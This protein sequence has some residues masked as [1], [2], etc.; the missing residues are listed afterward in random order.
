VGQRQRINQ[1]I[2]CPATLLTQGQLIG[3]LARVNR[4]IELNINQQP[5]VAK[6]R[7]PRTGVRIRAESWQVREMSLA[8][9]LLGVDYAE[10]LRGRYWGQKDSYVQVSQW[11]V[12]EYNVMASSLRVGRWLELV[13]VERRSNRDGAY[14]H[15]QRP[16][17]PARNKSSTWI[18]RISEGVR[19]YYAQQPEASKLQIAK[20]RQARAEMAARKRETIFGANP[21]ERLNQLH[22]LKRKG[23]RRMAE[24][25]GVSRDYIRRE[26]VRSG[27]YL[28]GEQP[29]RPGADPGILVPCPVF[30]ASAIRFTGSYLVPV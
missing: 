30:E 10:V 5:L 7:L 6:I 11:L 3:W 24:E 19:R 13:G 22:I 14:L 27:I 9:I 15:S 29:P 21:S 28:K 17:N 1:E 2:D 23:L 18:Q 20:A 25:L 26:M 12:R 4:S 8:Q 16:D